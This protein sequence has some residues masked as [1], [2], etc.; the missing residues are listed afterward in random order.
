MVDVELVGSGVPNSLEKLTILLNCLLILFNSVGPLFPLFNLDL[1]V[2]FNSLL[3]NPHLVFLEFLEVLLNNVVPFFIGRD[4]LFC[5]VDMVNCYS[6][7][8][9][10]VVCAEA[11][12]RVIGP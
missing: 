1:L 5:G 10:L 6:F 12:L 4:Q 2:L 7:L 3:Y 9:Q 8:I 11:Y